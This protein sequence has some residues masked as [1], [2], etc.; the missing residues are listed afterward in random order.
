MS[1]PQLQ[2]ANPVNVPQVLAQ[3]IELHQRGRLVEAAKL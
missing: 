1:L 3:A 2:N